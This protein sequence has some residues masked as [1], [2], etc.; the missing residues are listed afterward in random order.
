VLHET[1]PVA[2]D[3]DLPLEVATLAKKKRMTES[4]WLECTD[5][6]PMLHFLKDIGSDRKLRLFG[7]ACFGRLLDFVEDTRLKEVLAVAEQ[8]AEGM[9]KD[10]FRFAAARKARL[11]MERARRAMPAQDASTL[12][13][14][15]VACA[16]YELMFIEINAPVVANCAGNALVWAEC[17]ARGVPFSGD[18]T[19]SRYPPKVI[20]KSTAEQ[21]WQLAVLRD[22]FGNPFRPV[23]IDVAVSTWNGATVPKLAKA[24]YSLQDFNRIPKL[25]DALEEAGCRSKSILQHCRQPGPHIRG[26]WVVDLLLGKG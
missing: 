13:R 15:F 25:G 26:C 9:A 11:A 3:A 18:R 1:E 21:E 17:L 19:L 2:I 6:Q 20:A 4:Q 16:A 14:F 7:C 5:P 22:V 12:V 23:S 24:I 8:V 10:R